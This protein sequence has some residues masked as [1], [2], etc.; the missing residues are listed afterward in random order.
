[1]SDEAFT[2]ATLNSTLPVVEDVRRAREVYRYLQP[3]HLVAQ[4]LPPRSQIP[5]VTGATDTRLTHALAPF[6]QLAALRCKAQRAL[7]K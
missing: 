5:T 4:P 2:A 1:M 3:E 7:L 6:V